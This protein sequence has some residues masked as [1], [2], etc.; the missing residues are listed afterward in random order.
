MTL[1]TL[2]LFFV[3]AVLLA[4]TPGPDNIFVL[5]QSLA[6]GHRT[7]LIIVL[8]LCSGLIIHTAFVAFGVAAMVAASPWL[9]SLL[10]LIGAAYLLYLAWLNW[11]VSASV[12]QNKSLAVLSDW[13]M[14]R[15]GF[16]MNVTNPKVALFFLAF[17]PQ[18]VNAA[19]DDVPL[20]ILLLGGLFMLSTLL[21]FGGIAMLAGR[22]S[23]YLNQSEQ[24]RLLLNRLVSLLFVLI[25]LNLLFSSL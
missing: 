19:R 18:F 20:Q 15:R 16:I 8:G 25:A 23:R 9:F 7:G 14:Y 11:R 2:T 1:D 17:L 10:K 13:H 6:F 5:G 22:Y 12:R 21:V 24:R 3:T 4:L